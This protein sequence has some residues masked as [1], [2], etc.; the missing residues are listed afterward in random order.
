MYSQPFTNSI[1]Y[2]TLQSASGH[3][4]EHE[5]SQCCTRQL[6]GSSS[7]RKFSCLRELNQKSLQ[8]FPF[9]KL[10]EDMEEWD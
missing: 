7:F 1:H 8:F 10:S 9:A 3:L 4:L 6:T 2:A 5:Q